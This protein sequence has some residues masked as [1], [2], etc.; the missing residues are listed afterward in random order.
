MVTKDDSSVIP[1]HVY[2]RGSGKS[3]VILDSNASGIA[4]PAMIPHLDIGEQRIR[5]VIL[6]G[7]LT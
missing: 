7:I 1:Q 6:G 2:S 4:A 3:V 5:A